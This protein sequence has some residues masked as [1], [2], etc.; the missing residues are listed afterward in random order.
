MFFLSPRVFLIQPLFN[1]L[2]HASG[3]CC[4]CLCSN[5]KTEA[6]GG[7]SLPSAPLCC[8]APKPLLFLLLYTPDSESRG[9]TEAVP[10]ERIFS[11]KYFPRGNTSFEVLHAWLASMKTPRTEV[12]ESNS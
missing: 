1:A 7:R 11:A 2:S 10:R 8:C 9:K 5:K 6:L 3:V 4:Y 12:H